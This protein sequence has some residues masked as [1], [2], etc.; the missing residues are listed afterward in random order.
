MSRL[1]RLIHIL[2]VACFLGSIAVY[3]ALGPSQARADPQEFRSMRAAILTG[4]ETVTVP[5]LGIVFATGC[6]LLWQRRGHVP[7]W[8]WSKF[9]IGVLLMLNA[10]L[11]VGPAVS[12]AAHESALALNAGGHREA[13]WVAVQ[14]ETIFGAV[15]VALALIATAL[16]VW[17]PAMKPVVGK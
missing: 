16:A 11:L 14:R 8:A 5:A 10:W 9:L 17:R 15:N 7:R 12:M 3:V 6:A 2:G 1:I 4:T 13:A